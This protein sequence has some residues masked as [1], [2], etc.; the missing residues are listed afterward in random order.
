MRTTIKTF[1]L[2]FLLSLTIAY[3]AADS[4]TV[5]VGNGI[6]ADCGQIKAIIAEENPR[7]NEI[8]VEITIYGYTTGSETYRL[9]ND[10]SLQ[11]LQEPGTIK[12][13]V[14]VKGKSGKMK[15]LF[16]EGRG[17]DPESLARSLSKEL[18][19]LIRPYLD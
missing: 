16:T 11:I 3:S 4:L 18:S 17:A 1:F 5:T 15:T 9:S 6:P 19:V 2:I 10:G 7:L 14:R 12:A 8:F 13:M